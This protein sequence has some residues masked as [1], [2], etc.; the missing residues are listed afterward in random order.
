MVTGTLVNAEFIRLKLES[1]RNGEDR[2]YWCL[3]T[4][5]T[6]NQVKLFLSLTNYIYYRIYNQ[7]IAEDSININ[8]IFEAN[9][10]DIEFATPPNFA[11]PASFEAN[12][13]L[14]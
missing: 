13:Q 5:I 3:E 8:Q 7:V 1:D 12:I 11:K 2:W 14:L 4:N 10:H 6:A 9:E